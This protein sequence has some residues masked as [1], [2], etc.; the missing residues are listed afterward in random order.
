L[1]K[2]VAGNNGGLDGGNDNTVALLFNMLEGIE[3][4]NPTH[5]YQVLS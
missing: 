1:Y 4:Q 2:I 3:E 5:K